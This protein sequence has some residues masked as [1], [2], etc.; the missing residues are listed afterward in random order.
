MDLVSLGI[1]YVSFGDSRDAFAAAQKIQRMHPRW[2]VRQMTAREYVLATQYQE[3]NAGFSV[4]DFQGWVV[5]RV[6]RMANSQT[7]RGDD[8]R[9]LFQ[10]IKCFLEKFGDIKGLHTF[11]PP[12]A[13]SSPFP[14]TA[15]GSLP[16]PKSP[17]LPMSGSNGVSRNASGCG[18]WGPPKGA[19]NGQDEQNYIFE[20]IAEF[21][22][23][24]SAEN[25]VTSLNGNAIDVSC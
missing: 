10:S 20:I 23:T 7:T 14:N 2:H 3:R 16:S 19:V 13:G 8:L 12:S 1:V 22:D 25:A 9:G 4:S 17:A 11:Y 18:I 6:S 5:V 24:L 21:F 15:I